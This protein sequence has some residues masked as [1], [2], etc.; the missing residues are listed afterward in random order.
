[1]NAQ[2]KHCHANLAMVGS[3]GDGT[4]CLYLPHDGHNKAIGRFHSIGQAKHVARLN[5]YQVIY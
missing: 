1:M 4:Y 5:G 2:I 3:R